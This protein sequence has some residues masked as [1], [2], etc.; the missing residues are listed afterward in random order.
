[1]DHLGHGA[2]DAAPVDAGHGSAS[3]RLTQQADGAWPVRLNT[4]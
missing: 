1:L 2:S 4:V 3:V